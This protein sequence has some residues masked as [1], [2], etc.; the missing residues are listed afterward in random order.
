MVEVATGARAMSATSLIRAK[1]AENC[2]GTPREFDRS[3][4]E[5]ELEAAFAESAVA[6]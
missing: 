5:S 6:V 4:A 3:D 1:L 2:A